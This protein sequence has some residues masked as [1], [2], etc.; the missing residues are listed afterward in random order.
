[1]KR[2]KKRKKRDYES[3]KKKNEEDDH[4]SLPFVEHDLTREWL[5]PIPPLPSVCES[6]S[7]IIYKKKKKMTNRLTILLASLKGFAYVI[8]YFICLKILFYVCKK[9]K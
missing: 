4:S 8:I 7:S 6:I 5:Y 2:K 1:M 9:K 3:C